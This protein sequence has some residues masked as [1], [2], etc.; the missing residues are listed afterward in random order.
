MK[1][2]AKDYYLLYDDEG[3]KASESSE[4]SYKLDSRVRGN[5]EGQDRKQLC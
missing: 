5:D 4:F 2:T 1:K 3:S